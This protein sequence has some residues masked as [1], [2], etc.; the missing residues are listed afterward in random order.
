MRLIV[1]AVGVRGR[2]GCAEGQMT[3]GASSQSVPVVIVVGADDCGVL[4]KSAHTRTVGTLL[5]LA[6]R[7]KGVDR[8]VV[9]HQGPT[10]NRGL[11]AVAFTTEP[12]A[13]MASLPPQPQLLYRLELITLTP[14]A[15]CPAAIQGIRRRV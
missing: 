2:G 9:T 8:R 7:A 3:G 12:T 10:T 1:G 6:Q 14:V 11:M 15:R 4:I 13:Y 5:Q